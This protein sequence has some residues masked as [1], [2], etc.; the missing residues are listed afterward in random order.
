MGRG[1]GGVEHAGR[2]RGLY[3]ERGGMGGWRVGYRP[4]RG[5]EGRS[6]REGKDGWM[7]M[8]DNPHFT[9]TLSRCLKNVLRPYCLK[10][11]KA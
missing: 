8:K 10:K 7:G 9:R 4:C 2:Q 1:R 3:G 11:W 5:M 6:E